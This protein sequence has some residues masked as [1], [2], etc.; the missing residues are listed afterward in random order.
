MPF[1]IFV[2]QLI[3]CVDAAISVSGSTSPVS[4]SGSIPICI[5]LRLRFRRAQDKSRN[6]ALVGQAAEA[7]VNC[8]P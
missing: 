4:V 6:L 8:K 5:R 2:A 7:A 1:E 3:A